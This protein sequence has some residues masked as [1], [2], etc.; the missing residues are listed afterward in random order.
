MRMEN[1]AELVSLPQ[2]AEEHG[3]LLQCTKP[4]KSIQNMFIERFN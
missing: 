3:V 1:G 4:G 2:W